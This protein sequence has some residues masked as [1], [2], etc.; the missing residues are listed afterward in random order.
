MKSP[1]AAALVL[2]L[3]AASGAQAVEQTKKPPAAKAQAGKPAAKG[4]P[5][6]DA[7]AKPKPADPKTAQAKP[8]DPKPAD[9]KAAAPAAKPPAPAVPD[10]AKAAIGAAAVGGAAAA[11][12]VAAQPQAPL[13]REEAI[14]RAE[15]SLNSSP[16]MTA[17]F[18]Q[19][20]GDGRR[21]EGKLYV[22]KVGRMRFEYAQPAT[23]E[24][25][26][27]GSQVAVRDRKLNTQDL[28]FISQTPLKF[29][30]NEKIDLEKDVKLVDVVIDDAGASISI[31]DKATFGGTSKIKLIF[32]SKTFTLKQWQVSDPQGYETLVSLFN[33]DRSRSPDPNLFKI[34]KGSLLDF[35]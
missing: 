19:I 35:H 14:K 8:A 3:L 7:K 4:K 34:D 17:D 25:V 30:L 9:P 1:L 11:V 20:G 21:A 16:V 10:A 2:A 29:L 31:E 13:T 32:D 12:A 22:H 5:V 18:V 6:A 15:A 24:V 28:Y 33:V 23:M 26:S 27:D